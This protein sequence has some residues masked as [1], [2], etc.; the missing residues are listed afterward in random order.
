MVVHRRDL[1]RRTCKANARTTRAAGLRPDGLLL[2]PWFLGI[3]VASAIH[4]LVPLQYWQKMRDFFDDYG[5]M[6]CSSEQN[7]GSNGM[8][9]YCYNEIVMKLGRS[10]RR[11]MKSKAE[12]RFERSLLRQSRLAKK[13]LGRFSSKHRADSERRRPG[14]IDV[15]NPVY[16]ALSPL[17]RFPC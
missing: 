16:E 6:I 8:C 14:K 5:C 11:R 9:Q 13:L 10:A 12:Q 2:Q 7:Y 17:P 3:R 1:T 15:R 4:A